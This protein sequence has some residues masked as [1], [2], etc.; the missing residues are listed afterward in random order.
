M[1]KRLSI[2][3]SLSLCAAF[4][5]TLPA[6]AENMTSEDGRFSYL[7]EDGTATI[8]SYHYIGEADNDTVTI[9]DTLGGS[10]VTKLAENAFMMNCVAEEV[11]FP[12]TLKEIGD[13]CFAD[14][15]YLTRVV[16]PE[17]L[18]T[19]GFEAF[20][21][22]Y[23]LAEV[24]VPD[25]VTAVGAF[26]FE[27]TK[28]QVESEEE[29]I[30]FGDL[31][32]RYVG[33]G[34]AVEIPDGVT[35]ICA[36]SFFDCS[37]VTSVR[38][39]DSVSVI[40]DCAFEYCEKLTEIRFP[41]TLESLAGD[42]LVL[43]A[44]F[45]QYPDDCVMVGDILY[46]YKGEGDAVTIPDGTRVIGASAFER[47][48]PLTEITIPAGVEE[49]RFAAF[50][51]CT[52]LQVIT[53][54]DTLKKIGELCFY[55]CTSLER[56]ELP[57]SLTTLDARAFST[58]TALE[59]MTIP[60]S[61]TE[62]GEMAVGYYYDYNVNE[63]K[64]AEAFTLYS[65]SDAVKQYAQENGFTLQSAGDAPE[66]PPITVTTA[67]TTGTTDDST[68]TAEKKSKFPW[69]VLSIPAAGGVIAG[70]CIAKRKKSK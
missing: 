11:I 44:W 37:T 58:C 3:L 19:I 42:A 62:I 35:T 61:V 45:E 63:Y 36:Y 47:C 56:A 29:L 40:G 46:K 28:W 60:Q 17:G 23:A 52:A 4:L 7:I 50:Y 59:Q 65:D 64:R 26:A 38:M 34:G 27:S 15:S 12:D 67:V 57:Q 18:E 32:Y 20:D 33:D 10:P 30:I 51:Q 25:S 70:V 55:N 66:L 69:W 68:D 24:T 8:T 53:L 31:L 1:K 16:L 6:A 2:L 48:T 13:E 54:P 14:C 41:D 43:T 22:C 21:N 49:L 9:P 5:P 39:P